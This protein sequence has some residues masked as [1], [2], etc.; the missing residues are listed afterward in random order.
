MSFF[1][2]VFA[3]DFEG[4]WVLGD[5]HHSPK[6]VVRQNSGRGNEYV[7]VHNEGPYDLSGDDAD[8]TNSCDTLEIMYAL[9]EPKNWAEISVDITAGAASSA[10]VTP[11]E[12]VAALNDDTLFAE[13]FTASLSNFE[14][15]ANRT[16][17]SI[18]QKKP[19]TEMRFYIKNGRAEEKL[20]FNARAGVQE[21][22]VYFARHTME[23]RF[24]YDD[25]Q[26]QLIALDITSEVDLNVILDAVDAH[27]VA[28][29]FGWDGT[30]EQADWQLLRGRSGLF[31]FTNDDGSTDPNTKIIY[32]AGALAGDLAKKI[33]VSGA[34]TFVL[35]H[36]LVDADL[37]TPP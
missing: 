32:P 34:D 37:I 35:P 36:T 3:A 1:Q 5:R 14:G 11:G 9:R 18:R 7:V 20:R 6:F 26:N 15:Y 12:I 27:G 8:G 30:T 10:A 16:R 25:S 13:R 33:I 21:L 19:I 31:D 24:A 28:M 22:P 17:V 2:N 29:E 23:N 4:N